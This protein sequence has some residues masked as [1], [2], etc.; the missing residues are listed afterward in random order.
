MIALVEVMVV[1]VTI[2]VMAMVMVM[3]MLI[4]LSPIIADLTLRWGLLNDFRIC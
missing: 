2:V 4:G 3:M 1:I